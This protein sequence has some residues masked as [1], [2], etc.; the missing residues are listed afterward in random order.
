VALGLD[1]VDENALVVR[2]HGL[3][4]HPELR[5]ESLEL[6]VQLGEAAG[7]SFGFAQEI[8]VGA[9]DDEDVHGDLG[10]LRESSCRPS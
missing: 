5:G 7:I 1:R 4:G 9:V 8:E 3:D 2:L 6:F 10:S